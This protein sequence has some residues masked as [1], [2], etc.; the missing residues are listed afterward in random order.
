MCGFTAVALVYKFFSFTA[1]PSVYRCAD[2][3]LYLPCTGVQFYHCTFRVQVRSFTAVP[4]VYRCAVLP[5]YLPCTGAQIYCCTFRVQVRS[6]TAV[7]F[8]HRCADL[9]LYLPCTQ[10]RRLRVVSGATAPGPALSIKKTLSTN[11]KKF[12]E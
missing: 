10:R 8:V 5:L 12:Y 7:P 4:S 11:R 9:P 6:F 3:L 1:V 2:L